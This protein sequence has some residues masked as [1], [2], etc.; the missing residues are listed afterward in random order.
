MNFQL[1]KKQL[2]HDL[3]ANVTLDILKPNGKNK[4]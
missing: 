4:T 3:L 2:D 1:E